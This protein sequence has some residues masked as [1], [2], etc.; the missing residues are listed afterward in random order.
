VLVHGLWMPGVVMA[1]L[2]RRL[3]RAGYRCHLF[4]YASHRRPLEANAEQL[5]RFAHRRLQGRPA[6]YIGHSLGGLVVMHMLGAHTELA[7]GAVVLL[8]TPAQGCL[9]ARRVEGR[10]FGRWMLGASTPLWQEGAEAQWTRPEPLGVV[11]GT[12][13]F[14]IARAVVR[15]PGPN[16]GVVRVEE[17]AVEGMRERIVL[18]VAHSA[19]IVSRRVAAQVLAFLTHGRFAAP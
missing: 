5:S 17:T 8:G 19:M 3:A 11:A 16:D 4:T 6:H 18:P 10:R 9:S 1:P 12:A 15:L 14:G 13:H 2:G 7:V